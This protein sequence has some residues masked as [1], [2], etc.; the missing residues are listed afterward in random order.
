MNAIGVPTNQVNWCKTIGSRGTA[1]NGTVN[2][3][4]KEFKF[5]I[6]ENWGVKSNL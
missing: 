4:L 1:A 2:D 6:K 3:L 5:Y